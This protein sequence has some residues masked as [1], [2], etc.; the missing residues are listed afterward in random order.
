MSHVA[1]PEDHVALSWRTPSGGSGHR[2]ISPCSRTALA[3]GGGRIPGDDGGG[4]S[5]V[6]P[7]VGA[8][9][10]LVVVADELTVRFVSVAG[11][12]DGG[13]GEGALRARETATQAWGVRLTVK[14]GKVWF[15]QVQSVH[16]RPGVGFVARARMSLEGES[17]QKF[18]LP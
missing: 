3:G 6:W 8:E 4:G 18:S 14:G 9:P 5:Q 13:E 10:P 16:I 2:R 15:Q 7:G 1:H 12:A 11:A 17:V